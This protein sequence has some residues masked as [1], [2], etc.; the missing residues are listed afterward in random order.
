MGLGACEHLA[1]CNSYMAGATGFPGPEDVYNIFSRVP[2]GAHISSC[3][4]LA[5]ADLMQQ[6]GGTLA[7]QRVL[8]CDQTL[9]CVN[10]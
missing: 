7:Q 6:P 10:L 4:P 2:L 1:A 9:S 5:M 8:T 3:M